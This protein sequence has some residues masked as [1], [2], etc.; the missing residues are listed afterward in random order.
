MCTQISAFPVCEACIQISAFPVYEAFS[1][2]ENGTSCIYEDVAWIKNMETV[3]F[4]SDPMVTNTFHC[5]I[6]RLVRKSPSSCGSHSLK[7]YSPLFDLWRKPSD[8]AKR[9]FQH[10][11]P[12]LLQQLL[13]VA[14][15]I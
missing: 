4:L 14:S 2:C 1:R 13:T 5:D 15:G 3:F 9:L 7:Y 12:L 6:N 10:V 8:E 11:W